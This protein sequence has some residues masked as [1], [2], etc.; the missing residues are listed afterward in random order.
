MDLTHTKHMESIPMLYM[1]Q[2]LREDVCRV[3]LARDKPH[4]NLAL[5]GDISDKMVSN[6]EVFCPCMKYRVS[7]SFESTI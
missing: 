6:I 7:N 4:C 3:L 1:L 2:T 5:R